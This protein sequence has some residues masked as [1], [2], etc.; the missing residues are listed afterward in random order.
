MMIPVYFCISDIVPT[1]SNRKRRIIV[2]GSV[3]RYGPRNQ[4]PAQR[5]WECKKRECNGISFQRDP[6][7]NWRRKWFRVYI[8]SRYLIDSN[9]RAKKAEH[10]IPLGGPRNDVI[11]FSLPGVFLLR[12]RGGI[13]RKGEEGRGQPGGTQTTAVVEGAV[14]QAYEAMLTI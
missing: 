5:G 14:R 3:T 6:R 10:L 13:A 11:S 1:S 4:L 9:V 12:S 2:Q 8:C 7:K